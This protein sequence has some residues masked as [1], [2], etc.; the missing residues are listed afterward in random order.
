MTAPAA[1]RQSVAVSRML[2]S[3]GFGCAATGGASA[4]AIRPVV[5]RQAT[6]SLKRAA[7]SL[8][9]GE[10]VEGR[11]G[12]REQ[13]DVARPRRP[14]AP[15]DRALEVPAPASRRPTA[16]PIA[17]AVL[18]DQV[19]RGAGDGARAAARSPGP[20]ACPPRIRCTRRVEGGERD[21]RRGDVG[22][23]GVVDVADAVVAR[24]PPRG[25]ARRRANV[26]SPARDRLL[27]DARARQTAAARPRCRGCAAPRSPSSPADDVVR[28]DA[29]RA[30]A[31]HREL[32]DRRRL[33]GASGGR[34]AGAWRRGR[35]PACRAGRGGRARR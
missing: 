19:D 34:T 26:R 17:P 5:R 14:R 8:E 31:G 18:A 32:G 16:A 15:R 21:E 22:G 9:V 12:R 27:G 3:R 28:A 33:V 13:H 2:Y 35:P 11:A 24:R 30:R 7:A 10:L 29:R 23:L 20:C 4:A 25:G 1:S 6:S